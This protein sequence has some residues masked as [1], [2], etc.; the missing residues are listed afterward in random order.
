MRSV[1]KIAAIASVSIA[2]AVTTTEVCDPCFSLFI[3]TDLANSKD[4][5]VHST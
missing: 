3:P 4:E 2:A 1:F 5:D